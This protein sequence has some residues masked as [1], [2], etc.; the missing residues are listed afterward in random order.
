MV[1]LLCFHLFCVISVGASDIFHQMTLSSGTF[2]AHHDYLKP[3]KSNLNSIEYRLGFIANKDKQWHNAYNTPEYGLGISHGYF[4]NQLLGEVTA[5]FG[6]WGFPMVRIDKIQFY[7][8]VEFGGAYLTEIYHEVKNPLNRAI[9]THWNANV[10]FSL[11]A[12]YKLSDYWAAVGSFGLHHFSNGAS[13]KP[14]SGINLLYPRLG[15]MYYPQKIPTKKYNSDNTIKKTHLLDVR[16]GMASKQIDDNRD[17]FYTAWNLSTAWQY[18]FSN[19]YYTGAGIDLLY[20]GSLVSKVSV[21]VGDEKALYSAG[22]FGTFG[23]Q[24]GQFSIYTQAGTYLH[25]SYD[26]PILYNRLGIKLFPVKW[27]YIHVSMRSHG[28]KA[29]NLEV[30]VGVSPRI[31]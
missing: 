1:A 8:N 30:G 18:N 13:R 9:S 11:N 10:D 27:S 12:Q 21:P 3:L 5:L 28:T 16:Y 19:K 25:N 31:F 6:F 2:I 7:F 20:D 29:D 23:W 4:T 17:D 14:N 26:R 22:I 24:L 15:L